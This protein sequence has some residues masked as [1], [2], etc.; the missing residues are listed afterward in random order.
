MEKDGVMNIEINNPFVNWGMG[1][2]QHYNHSKYWKVRD[3]V[4]NPNSKI[5]KI[6]RY[7]YLLK[8]K[9]ADAYNCASFGTDFEGGATFLTP[10]ILEHDINGI[11]ISH[12]V[13]IGSNCTIFQRVTIAEGAECTSAEIGDNCYIGAGAVIIGNVKIGNNAT[14]GSNA[15]VTKD[16]PENAVAV[17]VPEKVVRIKKTAVEGDF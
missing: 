2:I 1:K 12:Y 4:V 14:I 8:I 11:I 6:I 3:A 7:R 15:V 10:P 5:P 17:G 13:K 16:I 9:K